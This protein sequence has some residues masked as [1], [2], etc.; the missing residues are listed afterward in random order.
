MAMGRRERRWLG[1]GFVMVAAGLGVVASLTPLRSPTNVRVTLDATGPYTSLTGANDDTL[2][3]CGTSRW[4][5][6]EP[7]V[8]IDPHQPDTITIGANDTCAGVTSD[9]PWMGLYRSRDGGSTW[10][11]SLVP[12][13]PLDTTAHAATSPEQGSCGFSSDPA[14]SFDTGGTLFYGFICVT[15]TPQGSAEPDGASQAGDPDEGGESGMPGFGSTAPEAPLNV[16]ASSAYV[17]VFDH[18]GSHFVRTSLV[19]A[20]DPSH[21]VFE[22]K[23]D[24]TVDQSSGPGSG[25]VYVA[26]AEFGSSPGPTVMFARS[27]DHGATFS[28]P[29]RVDRTDDFQQFA[30]M[31]VGPDGRLYVAFRDRDRLLVARSTDQGQSFAV[32]ASLTIRPFDSWY[33]SGGGEA[34]RDCGDAIDSCPSG[35]TFP[36]FVSEPAIAADGTGEHLM[37]SEGV[38]GG[39]G[40]IVGVNSTDGAHWSPPAP[41]DG[42]AAGHQFMPTMASTGGTLAALFYD[43]RRDPSY[44]PTR[45]P[46]NRPDG[47]NAGPAVDVILARSPDGGRTWSEIRVTPNPMVIGF[48]TSDSARVPF[49]GDYLGL[50][51]WD[52][53]FA[54]AWTDTRDVVTGTDARTGHEQPGDGFDVHVPCTFAPDSI[55]APEYDR[56]ARSDPCLRRGGL[57]VNIYASVISAR[58]KWIPA[59]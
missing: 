1:A 53:R 37:W 50:S 29:I 58:S 9:Y 55:E 22:D 7:S 41:V 40:R 5:Q 25:N 33:F 31:A 47:S 39:R 15:T 11:D 21:G 13:Y 52:G 26:W 48:E 12:G 38:K 44:G 16:T 4:A 24:L 43:S 19:S 42:S 8:A 28:T 3:E 54:F 57:D 27:T 45:P 32:V 2:R 6:N 14:L 36:R 56:P 49:I 10:T 35:Y 46:G 23:I 51:G 20:G 17:A 30:D 34:D 59:S 18:D